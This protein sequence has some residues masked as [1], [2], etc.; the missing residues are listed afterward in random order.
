M[1]LKRL[2]RHMVLPDW[3]VRRAFSPQLL[4]RIAQ[5][6]AASEAVHLGELRLVV[7]ASL[8]LSG[9][10]R[11]ASPRLR[12]IDLF[13]QLGVWDT[14]HN[15]GVLIYLQL[16]DRRVEIVADRGIDAKVGQEFWD[17]V[18]QKME[19]AFAA[20][21]FENGTL[22]ALRTITNTLRE[23]FPASTGNPDELPNA[24]LLL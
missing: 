9:L 16:V 22:L 15:S 8:P 14:E 3:W 6:V 5:A 23:H 13:S 11:G 20:G 4:R 19:A 1:P 10:L 24:P 21:D 2:L 12:A 18:C 7:E 17:S